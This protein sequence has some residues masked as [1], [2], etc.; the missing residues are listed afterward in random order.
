V[1]YFYPAWASDN[2][3]GGNFLNC[4]L[5]LDATHSGFNGLLV[6]F[7]EPMSIAQSNLGVM[8][9]NGQGVKQHYKIAKKYYRPSLR[10]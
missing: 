8:Y 7:R 2:S 10:Q 3:R 6:V 4:N 5:R 9:D 1:L